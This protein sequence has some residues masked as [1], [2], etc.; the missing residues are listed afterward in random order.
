MEKMTLWQQLNQ[1]PAWALKPINAGRLKGKTDI[2]PQWRYQVA[3]EV[4]GACGIG[5]KYEIKRLWSEDGCEGQKF[6]FAEILFY[7]RVGETWSDP[8]PGIG[9]SMLID[10]ETKGLHASDEGYKM[11]VT[12]A[13]SVAM[14][15]LGVAAD[16]YMGLWD[17]SK[18]KDAPRQNENKPALTPRQ[19]LY[20]MMKSKG[21]S[22]D[23]MK[24]FSDFVG[25][26]TEPEMKKFIETFEAQYE[27]WHNE[28]EDVPF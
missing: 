28:P 4:L 20:N 18:Y 5:W 3:T 27:A 8:I 24:S 12:D 13:L 22:N 25:A 10:K 23:Q 19:I 14:K 17:G 6:A 26:K 21:L 7:H 15:M 11:A 16:I 2:N 1:P 9:G